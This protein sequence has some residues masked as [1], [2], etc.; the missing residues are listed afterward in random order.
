MVQEQVNVKPKAQQWWKKARKVI[1]GF[2]T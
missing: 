1:Y 2:V